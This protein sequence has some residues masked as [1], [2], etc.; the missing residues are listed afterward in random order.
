MMDDFHRQAAAQARDIEAA[1]QQAHEDAVQQRTQRFGIS[2]ALAE[3]LLRL[4][5]RVGELE[6]E[7]KKRA[8]R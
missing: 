6:R 3:Y 8:N 7:L 4:E 5:T 1:R 2:H